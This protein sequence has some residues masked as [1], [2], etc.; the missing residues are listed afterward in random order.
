M[1]LAHAEIVEL[2]AEARRGIGIWALLHGQLD[3]E[4]DGGRADIHGTTAGRLHDPRAAAG[5]DDVVAKSIVDIERTAAL[6]D[7]PP[8]FPRRLVIDRLVKPPPRPLP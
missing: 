8:E 1:H 5:G 7:D 3:V 6:G 2:E 4:A